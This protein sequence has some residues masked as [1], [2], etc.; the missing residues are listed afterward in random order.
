MSPWDNDKHKVAK[1]KQ[2]KTRVEFIISLLEML[3]I[4][5]PGKNFSC[6]RTWREF[7]S[8]SPALL[9]LNGRP[10]TLTAIGISLWRLNSQLSYL[11][12]HFDGSDPS[13][14]DIGLVFA[15]TH[16]IHHINEALRPKCTTEE[17]RNHN[18]YAYAHSTTDLIER[19]QRPM[20]DTAEDT[21]EANNKMDKQQAK[22]LSW[23]RTMTDY[24]DGLRSVNH[25][26]PLLELHS[27]IFLAK[28]ARELF[29]GSKRSP[30]KTKSD[31]PMEMAEN[32]ILCPAT[33]TGTHIDTRNRDIYTPIHHPSTPKP[34]QSTRIHPHPSPYIRG[35]SISINTHP[36]PSHINPPTPIHIH[37]YIH[38]HQ[39]PSTPIHIHPH[40][41]TSI[42]IHIQPHTAISI[43]K[44]WVQCP[45]LALSLSRSSTSIHIHPHPSTSKHI[46]PHP[47]SAI[48]HPATSISRPC[49]IHPNPSIPTHINPYTYI[50]ISRPSHRW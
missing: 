25:T 49:R 36:H 34:H 43:N 8:K 21:H 14:T 1:A 5:P 33:L 16:A 28:Q 32:L 24:V 31:A 13:M 20:V 23:R 18:H 26:T 12:N 48:S 40:P 46:H 50:S 42:H 29:T 39:Y 37:P 38:I 27:H 41:S 15:V 7:F 17:H 19:G 3:G 6:G 10:P 4:K 47:S 22:K 9:R 35:S 45:Q 2:A 30:D 11:L 44:Q